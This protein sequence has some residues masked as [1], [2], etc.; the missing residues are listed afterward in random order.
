MKKSAYGLNDAPRLWWNKLDRALRTMGLVPTRADRCCYVLYSKK[1]QQWSR[2]VTDVQAN[3]ANNLAGEFSAHQTC[4]P[5]RE[6]CNWQY[7]KQKCHGMPR[8][9]DGECQCSTHLSA[10]EENS[11]CRYA[12]Q[13][14][15]PMLD[16]EGAIELMTDPVHASQAHGNNI[17]GI[18]SIH[19]DDSY[20]VSYTHLRAHET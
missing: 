10:K 8:G 9:H 3:M 4:E 19:V 16:L 17:E 1:K 15:P 18:V 11:D 12:P 20:T 5:C 6:F 14:G 2:A 7:C 13:N